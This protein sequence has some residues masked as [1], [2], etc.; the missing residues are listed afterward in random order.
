M[1]VTLDTP[2]CAGCQLCTDAVPDVFVLND[3]GLAIA[4]VSDVPAGEEAAVKD[5]ADNCP[6]SAI[7]VD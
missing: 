1:H 6:T 2:S 4:K 5:A 3:E 7:S